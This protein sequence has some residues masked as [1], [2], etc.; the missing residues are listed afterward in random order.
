MCWALSS[1]KKSEKVETQSSEM[2]LQT[3]RRTD[4]AKFIEY[5]MDDEPFGAKKRSFR[6]R[7]QENKQLL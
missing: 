6:K 5:L 4:T 1:C 7:L 3:N 2:A